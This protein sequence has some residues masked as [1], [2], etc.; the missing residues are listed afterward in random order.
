MKHLSKLFH[1]VRPYWL[2]SLLSLALLTAVVLMD[3][4]IPRLIQR[5]IDD[6]IAQG[7]MPVVIQTT[8]IMLVISILSTLFAIGNNFLSVQ[9]GEAF[10]RDL[11]L[12]L[13]ER[14]LGFSFGNLDQLRTGQLIVRLTTDINVLQR[15]VR[16]ILRIGT[17]APLLMIGSLIL[18]FNTNRGLALQMLPLVLAIGLVLTV[19]IG[20]VGEMF[21]TVQ[22]KLDWLNTVLQ[23]NISGVR[24]VKAF[25][26]LEHET[27]RFEAA[28]QAFT[29]HTIKTMQIMTTMF[30]ALTVLTNLGVVIVIW[31]GGNL[32]VEGELSVGEIVAFVNYLMTTLTPLTIMGMLSQVLA[33]G[34]ASAERINEVL[35]MQPEVQDA[36]DAVSLPERIRGQVI[37]ENISFHYNGAVEEPV[38]SGIN[39]VAE[40]GQTVAILGAT[41]AGKTSLV[42]LIPRFY[43]PTGGR[44]LI[45]GLDVRQI[46]QDELHAHIG[47][48]LQEAVL[49]SGTVKEN[50][51]YGRPDASDAEITSAA[52]AAQAHEFILELPQ[53]YDSHVEQRGVN[54]SG[55]QKQRLALA[56]A[57]LTRP[58]IL[59]L[60]DSTSSVDVDTETKIQEALQQIMRGS[61]NFIVAQRISTVLNADKIIVIDGG[62]IAAEGA[63]AELIRTSPIYQEIY[64]S[65]LGG[66]LVR[67]PSGGGLL[68]QPHNAQPSGAHP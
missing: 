50:L 11:R 17:R 15:L 33:T 20:R 65:Q 64:D 62:K 61:T 66:G 2:Q 52:Q 53:G 43:D 42:N 48:V 32:A 28:N 27:Q 24:V 7:S 4:A 41:G 36:P 58:E 67:Q 40:P 5:I 39:L 9:A 68:R 34:I 29:E 51:S 21:F 23:E 31:S 47:V 46:R 56:R 14:V 55:G 19:F 44:V 54:L 35:K 1:F 10:G 45:D 57:L 8:I 37:F 60:D 49:F 13:F 22:Q 6:G 63:H 18:M 30:P 59:I 38:L 26:R 3:L 16:I 25:V 12:A